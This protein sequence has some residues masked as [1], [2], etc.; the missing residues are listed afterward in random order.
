MVTEGCVK[1]DSLRNTS[2]TLLVWNINDLFAISFISDLRKLKLGM[3]ACVL[4]HP[5]TLKVLG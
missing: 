2:V 5:Y 4:R 1:N 3:Y